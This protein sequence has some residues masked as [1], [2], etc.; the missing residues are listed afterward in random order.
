MAA[1]HQSCHSWLLLFSVLCRNWLQQTDALLI[2]TRVHF[3]EL[4]TS[5]YPRSLASGCIYPKDKPVA[6]SGCLWSNNLNDVH[7]KNPNRHQLFWEHSRSVFKTKSTGSLFQTTNHKSCV[8]VDFSHPSVSSC[9]PRH[10][11]PC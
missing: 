10:I 2:H 5:R 6:S 8:D 9:N 3:Q 7:L 1:F 11:P 4:L